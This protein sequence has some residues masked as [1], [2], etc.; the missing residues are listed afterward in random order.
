MGRIQYADC[1]R[2]MKVQRDPLRE[3]LKG[4]AV[5]PPEWALR[6]S[7]SA[8]D[9]RRWPRAYRRTGQGGDGDTARRSATPDNFVIP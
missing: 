9:R 7:P 8:A 3:P 4:G 2:V 6:R 1:E 5:G